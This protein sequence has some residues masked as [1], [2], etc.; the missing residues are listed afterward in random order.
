MRRLVVVFSIALAIMAVGAQAAIVADANSDLLAGWTDQPQ[1]GA[2]GIADTSGL[3]TWDVGWGDATV[4]PRNFD[5]PTSNIMGGWAWPDVGEP[6]YAWGYSWNG[7][8]DTG[9]ASYVGYE[10]L[11]DGRIKVRSPDPSKLT[12]CPTFRWNSGVAGVAT[13]YFNVSANDGGGG[14]VIG[15]KDVAAG[16]WY[17]TNFEN[18]DIFPV[19][20]PNAITVSF[21]KT[22]APGESYLFAYS[23]GTRADGDTLMVANVDVVPVPEPSSL[24]AL[25]T[26]AIGSLGLRRRF[27]K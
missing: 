27:R 10:M 23:G 4:N 20:D 14:Q 6:K 9:W 3:G 16:A 11:P 12:W 22:I 15:I 26:A 17:G 13:F 21:T 5:L 24:L 19:M 18:V 25:A 7:T 1:G 8:H 2:V